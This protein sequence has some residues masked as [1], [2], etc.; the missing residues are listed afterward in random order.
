M[1]V[2][3]L[4]ICS[5]NTTYGSKYLLEI[6]DIKKVLGEHCI[7]GGERHCQPQPYIKGHK[8]NRVSKYLKQFSPKN[9]LRKN[10]TDCS[11]ASE[12]YLLTLVR[13]A[14][15]GCIC[16]ELG[17]PHKASREASYPVLYLASS[18]S[19]SPVPVSAE[20]LAKASWAACCSQAGGAPPLA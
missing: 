12:D 14:G 11:L 6:L 8:Y 7:I 19:F 5:P 15:R 20:L 3:L 10:M 16:S 4:G 2:E 1:L 9:D 17:L 13:S 18:P